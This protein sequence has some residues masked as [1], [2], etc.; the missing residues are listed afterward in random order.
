M[1]DAKTAHLDAHRNNIRRY[2]ALLETHLTDVERGYIERQLS[3]EL[4]VLR[5]YIKW[6]LSE[7][8]DV[9][10]ALQSDGAHR[11]LRRPADKR[12]NGTGTIGGV[13]AGGEYSGL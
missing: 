1:V 5:E 8:Q 3:E 10:Q 11:Q 13:P 9:L 12:A 4:V 7:E 2:R 6:R